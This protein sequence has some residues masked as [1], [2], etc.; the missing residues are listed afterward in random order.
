MPRRE[1]RLL[2]GAQPGVVPS[3]DAGLDSI[4]ARSRRAR[5]RRDE[6][7]HVRDRIYIEGSKS[8]GAATAIHALCLVSGSRGKGQGQSNQE[9][10][11]VAREENKLRAPYVRRLLYVHGT[12]S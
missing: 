9:N 5:G 7:L 3:G 11:R 4:L 8:L 6:K 10:R 2:D 12:E 1:V